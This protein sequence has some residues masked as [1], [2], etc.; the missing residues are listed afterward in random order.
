MTRVPPGPLISTVSMG[1][2]PSVLALEWAQ[3]FDFFFPFQVALCHS[4]SVRGEYCEAVAQR[5]YGFCSIYPYLVEYGREASSHSIPIPFW[6]K[7]SI[8]IGYR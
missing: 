8:S 2:D 5:K 4:V 6:W 7:D 3:C 1:Q